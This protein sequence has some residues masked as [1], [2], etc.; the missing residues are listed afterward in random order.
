MTLSDFDHI[1]LPKVTVVCQST[2]GSGGTVHSTETAMLYLTTIAPSTIQL[3]AAIVRS[4]YSELRPL[5]QV[6]VED[7][8][9]GTLHPDQFFQSPDFID[10]ANSVL[11]TLLHKESR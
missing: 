11:L 6:E 2:A 3:G 7:L 10:W 9:S 1:R 8:L 5:P 4:L